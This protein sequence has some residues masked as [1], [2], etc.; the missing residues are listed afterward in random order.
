MLV[1]ASLPFEL[2]A[3]VSLAGLAFT[4]LELLVLAVLALWGLALATERRLP[5]IPRG[6]GPPALILLAILLISAIAAPAWRGVAL[7]FSARQAQGALLAFCLADQ[8]LSQGWPL[9]RRL[10]LALIAGA[11]ASALLGLLELTEAAPVLALLAIFKEQ[12]TMAGGLLRLS[13]T[14]AYANI[15]AMY[16]ES[17]LAVGLA[18]VGLAARKRLQYALYAA[19][20]VL[21]GAALLTYSRAALV[22]TVVVIALIMLAAIAFQRRASSSTSAKPLGETPRSAERV[23]RLCAVLLALTASVLV[24][25]PTFRVRITTPDIAD[26]YRA[27]YTVT[28]L[29]GLA[30]N[31]LVRQPVT[32]DNRGLVTWRSDGLRPVALSY[33]WL[34]PSTRRVVRYNGRRTILSQPIQP[35]GR[36]LLDAQVQAPEKAGQYILAWDMVIEHSSWFSELGTP[37]AEVLVTVSGQPVTSQ[38]APS[39]EPP[40]MPERISLHPAPPARSALWAAALRIWR[41]HPLLGIGPDVFRH[42]YGPEL[43][44]QTWDDRI[45]TNSLYLELLVGAGVAGLAAFLLLVA[46][47]LAK[48]TGILIALR[49]P[50]RSPNLWM[51]LGCGVGLLAFLIHGLLDMFLE[52]SATYLLLW[53]LIGALGSFS[54]GKK[55]STARSM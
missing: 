45:H 51:A 6:M 32:V 12:P 54:E 1:L 38:P 16:Y 23:A 40:G 30:P 21:F 41:A 27:D 28:Q 25:S 10:G 7:K 14:L 35:G 24:L 11:A 29:P 50:K 19:V 5:R 55:A 17:V 49:T 3:G 33:H 34:D 47:A 26:W 43:G 48:G 37:M 18:A 2:Y 42:V 39:P 4:N 8:L 13:G 9:A 46:L 44:L 22:T 52:Y 31:A 20:L 15:A 53:V 36:L